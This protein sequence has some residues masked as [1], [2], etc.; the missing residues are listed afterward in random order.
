MTWGDPL[1][2]DAPPALDPPTRAHVALMA[3]TLLSP[4]VLGAVAAQQLA[5]LRATGNSSVAPAALAFP[6]ERRWRDVV[7]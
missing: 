1:P 5:R 6:G 2:D 4:G 7:L 3:Q